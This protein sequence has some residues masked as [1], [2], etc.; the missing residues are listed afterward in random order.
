MKKHLL[1]VLLR[2][3]LA[4]GI[5]Q[6]LPFSHLTWGPQRGDTG[7]DALRFLLGLHLI[8]L[9]AAILYFFA[10]S[11]AH[12]LLRRRR[13]WAIA[14]ADGLIGGSLAV[15]LVYWGLTIAHPEPPAAPAVLAAVEA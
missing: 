4:N 5:W 15:V 2:C 12:L 11:G 7:P 9:A 10:A 8:G 6:V 1:L 14:L 13:G 3:T